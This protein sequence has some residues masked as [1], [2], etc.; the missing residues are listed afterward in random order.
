MIFKTPVL[1][2]EFLHVGLRN[3]ILQTLMLMSR[4]LWLNSE[5]WRNDTVYIV[6]DQVKMFNQIL[7]MTLL[8]KNQDDVLEIVFLA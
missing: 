5:F 7:H 3:N 1:V 6:V 2:F 4:H 8:E